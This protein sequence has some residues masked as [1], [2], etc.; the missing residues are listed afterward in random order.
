[1]SGVETGEFV[2]FVESL[3][4]SGCKVRYGTEPHCHVLARMQVG[5]GAR[6]PFSL[7]RVADGRWRYSRAG[8]GQLPEDERVLASIHDAIAYVSKAYLDVFAP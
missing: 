6:Y 5:Q 2:A 8:D 1:M 7:D 3:V 4:R